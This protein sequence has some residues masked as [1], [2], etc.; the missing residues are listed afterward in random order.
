M[1]VAVC[2]EK[3]NIHRRFALKLLL[4][5]G[6]STKW[7]TFGFMVTTAFM[8]MW[9]SNTATTSMMIPIGQAVLVELVRAR[10]GKSIDQEEKEIGEQ[11]VEKIDNL[12]ENESKLKLIKSNGDSDTFEFEKLDT[13][14]KDLCKLVCLCICYSANC[15]GIG[16]LTGTG[17]NLVLKGQLDQ[18]A[19]G[20]SGITFATWFIFGFPI[21]VVSVLINWVVLQIMFFGWRG[22]FTKSKTSEN[23]ERI[24]MVLQKQYEN[25]GEINFAQKAVCVHFVM[26]VLL[27]F[28]LEPEF[29]PGWGHFFK[30]GYVSDAV[31]GM[32]IAT[33]LFIFPSRRRSKTDTGEDDTNEIP[34]LLDWQTFVQKIPWG[35]TLLL[36]GGFALAFACQE[37]GLSLWL[38][39]QL[40]VFRD[41]PVWI[42]IF[43]ICLIVSLATE[44]ISNTAT[45][46]I[47]LPVLA[48][49][50]AGIHLHPTYLM[51]PASVACSFA[52][53]LPVAT[54]PNTIA[55]SYGY[56]KVTDM[57]PPLKVSTILLHGQFV[58]GKDDTNVIPPLLDWETFVQKIPWGVTLLQG[59]GLAL[60][61]ACQA[62]GMHIHPSYL[63]LPATVVC[64]FAF[65][66]TVSTPP[67]IIA[68]SYGYL[69]VT[70]MMK[71]GVFLNFSCV[72]IV[73]VAINTYGAAFLDLH[74]YPDWKLLSDQ[75]MN[76]NISNINSTSLQ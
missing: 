13:E 2:I 20:S 47:V 33:S 21:T 45:C 53:M 1:S 23:P 76:L 39:A 67:N 74:E 70:D 57:L 73:T 29:V 16:T 75:T 54:P 30:K 37:S 19:G 63:M 24:K 28:S 51:L 25:L 43:I 14:S 64:S 58:L 22:P 8:S 44:V 6:T 62:A 27:W 3:W 49:M 18:L 56:L 31:P 42:M 65:M 71:I 59:G 5:L 12:E 40:S 66:L 72:I 60:A 10:K 15:G 55:F 4:L 38:G 61:F 35:V 46:T 32:I 48:N 50:A 26:L 36:G 34:P 9:V 7:L 41:V 11:I 69:K 52:F 68:F 17:P